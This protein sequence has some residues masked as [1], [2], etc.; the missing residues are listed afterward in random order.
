MCALPTRLVKFPAYIYEN[1]NHEKTE[2]NIASA[3]ECQEIKSLFAGE[4][5]FDFAAA[6]KYAQDE[7]L[8]KDIHSFSADALENFIKNLHRLSA[9]SLV[10]LTANGTLSG[11]Y[12]NQRVIVEKET[13]IPGV[14][15]NF[16][17]STFFSEQTYSVL[18]KCF[19][20]RDAD[21]YKDFCEKLMTRYK[22]ECLKIAPLNRKERTWEQ[23]F[24][25]SKVDMIDVAN[26]YLEN[27]PGYEILRRIIA[28][29]AKPQE[30]PSKMQDFC[31]QL[32]A[33]IS[34]NVDPI[35]SA[36][37]ALELANIHPF[38]NGNGRVARILM[39]CILMNYGLPPLNLDTCKKQYYLAVEKSVA[40]DRS[41]ICNFIRSVLQQISAD[42]VNKYMPDH[43][44]CA[45]MS[46]MA[47][48]LV[49]KNGETFEL[50]AKENVEL[51]STL[52]NILNNSS[53][54]PQ[55]SQQFFPS[56]KRKL[57]KQLSEILKKIDADY[58]H[59]VAEEIKQKSTVCAIYLFVRA[60]DLYSQQNKHENSALCYFEAAKLCLQHYNFESA[61]FF[62]AKSASWKQWQEQQEFL[63]KLDFMRSQPGMNVS[64][65]YVR[66]SSSK[67]AFFSQAP[68]VEK[69]VWATLES[70][71]RYYPVLDQLTPALIK[72]DN[73]QMPDSKFSKKTSPTGWLLYSIKDSNK[74]LA[75]LNLTDKTAAT[76][77]A[78]MMSQIGLEGK[79]F[80]SDGIPCIGFYFTQGENIVDKIEAL[81]QKITE[82]M[83]ISK[84]PGC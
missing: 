61:Y 63:Q 82:T 6:L 53:Q 4:Q 34:A 72:I 12:L 77:L 33:M 35:E 10:L 83:S 64:S 41:Q 17:A 42:A 14:R 22:E 71:Q 51:Y 30:L 13:G 46:D 9:A 32:I 57:E 49:I 74:L 65:A 75:T 5:F 37:Y 47:E 7:F 55:N 16:N 43:V 40:G 54:L 8:L 66:T 2:V 19:G 15:Y 67:Q 11:E 48:F 58:L 28:I 21:F 76:K 73:I 1:F 29:P 60:A 38:A 50:V 24:H 62:A 20:K 70:M 31:R 68:M 69:R 80:N 23:S 81:K 84:A 25:A 79:Y 27:H 59:R 78:E 44:L 39:N 45:F 56:F 36:A 52:T 3:S 18:V 26:L